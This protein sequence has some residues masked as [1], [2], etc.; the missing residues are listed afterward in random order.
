MNYSSERAGT[1]YV[2]IIDNSIDSKDQAKARADAEYNKRNL[3]F[4]E[5]ELHTKGNP[6]IGAG[7]GINLSGFNEPFDNDY[8]IIRVRHLW[9]TF[10]DH[11]M[12]STVIYMVANKFK[13]QGGMI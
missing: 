12:Y 5:A 2:N 8:L 13:P 1:R 10:S 3:K 9:G 7:Q 11:Q 4:V 6:K